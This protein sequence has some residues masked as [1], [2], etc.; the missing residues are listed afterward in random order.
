MNGI[1]EWFTGLATIGG[2]MYFLAGFGFAYLQHYVRCKIRHR[3]IKIP[4]QI[5]GIAIGIVAIII[6]T[7][8]SQ[9]AYTTA[10]NTALEQKECNI[11]F[12]QSLIDRAKTTRED[13]DLSKE[14]RSIVFDWF[15]TILFPPPP[16]DKM[17]TNDPMRQQF[18]LNKTLETEDIFAQS[19]DR[20]TQVQIERDRHPYPDPTCG[21]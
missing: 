2:F 18:V 8:Q 15:H 10:K 1:A 16:Y 14:Q 7:F 5:T 12:R 19:I 21:K 9:I 13:N 11:Q 4:W 3:S 20:Q 6:V 17:S